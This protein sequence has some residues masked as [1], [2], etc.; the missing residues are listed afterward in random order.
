MREEIHV[1]DQIGHPQASDT[2]NLLC[3]D[4]RAALM[5]ARST[6]RLTLKMTPCPLR[7]GWASDKFETGQSPLWSTTSHSPA[8]CTLGPQFVNECQS[9]SWA[10]RQGAGQVDRYKP[11]QHVPISEFCYFPPTLLNFPLIS[12]NLRVF[13]ILYVFFFPILLWPWWMY[14][15]HNARRLLDAPVRN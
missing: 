1:T 12:L 5:R 14:A 6:C 10:D 2:N 15:S 4:Y 11:K 9:G 3:I 7:L 13:R 8:K